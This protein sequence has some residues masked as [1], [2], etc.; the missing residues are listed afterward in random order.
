MKPLKLT[1]QAFGPFVGTQDVD[2]SL[3]GTH[4]L[5][6]I[7]G[8]T[9]AGKST[10]LDAI[11]FALYGKTTGAE[12]EASQMRCDQAP[13][14]VLTQVI[15][16]FELAQKHY[17]IKR[18]PNQP[19]AKARGEGLTEHIGTADLWEIDGAGKEQLIVT[20][21]VRE[22]TEEIER[23]TGL[24]VEQFRQVMVLPQGK[25][26]QLLLADSADREKIFSK[27]FQTDI[28]KRIE[29]ALNEKARDILKDK[30]AHD[31][32][33]MGILEGA[34]LLTEEQLSEQLKHISPELKT[35]KNNKQKLHE[36][37]QSLLTQRES[38]QALQQQF[39]DYHRAMQQLLELEQQTDQ[40]ELNKQALAAA[41]EAI[42]ITPV[43]DEC[44]RIEKQQQ[45]S[46]NKLKNLEIKQS[47][48]QLDFEEAGH[49]LTLAEISASS[50]DDLKQQ[51]LELKRYEAKVEQLEAAIKT[52]QK[53]AISYAKSWN[54]YQDSQGLYDEKISLRK[55]MQDD[56]WRL[57]KKISLLSN[58]P[59]AL[60]QLSQQKLKRI[61]LESSRAEKIH[62]TKKILDV[63]G[64]HKRLT[65]QFITSEI[66]M[67]TLEMGW[68][69]GQAANLAAELHEG[70]P[71][72]VC[73]SRQHPQLASEQEIKSSAENENQQIQQVSL[74]Q[75][76]MAREKIELARDEKQKVRLQLDKLELALAQFEQAIL[77]LT[78]ELA[79]LAHESLQSLEL[80][81]SDLISEVKILEQ[82]EIQVKKLN[83]QLSAISQQIDG[84]VIATS[85]AR[86][87]AEADKILL[88]IEQANVKAIEIEL[89]KELTDKTV[90]FNKINRI[91][92][93]I[94]QLS[95]AL[96]RSQAAAEHCKT[97]LTQHES[98]QQMLWDNIKELGSQLLEANNICLQTLQ[99]S[100]FEDQG[101]YQKSKL[102][103]S[104]LNNLQ[105]SIQAFSQNL[106]HIKGQLVQQELS[107]KGKTEPDISRLEM[108]CDEM[109]IEFNA[110]EKDWKTLDARVDQLK[111]VQKKLKKAHD[112]NL[113]LE[114]NYEIYGTLSN[115]ATGRTGNN[116]SFQ[117]FVLSVLLDDVLIEA[118]RRLNVMTK[119][120]YQLLRKQDRSKGNKASGLEL[121][122]E[123]AY[124]G[125]SRS[126][127][128][129]SG[130]ESFLA[131]L[132]LALGLSDVVQQ[133]A[134]GI[135]LD[136][137][138][139]DEG[140]GSL[141]Q[142]SLDLAIRT[143]IDLQ[144]SGRTIGIISHVTELK[145]LMPL[146]L[147]VISS[148]TG[149]KIHT[150]VDQACYI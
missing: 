126:V 105:L 36:S 37:L 4:P 138:F 12:R 57:D 53:L 85:Q 130:G 13:A 25:F 27:L 43:F 5:F 84:L 145:Q 16:E 6:L 26:R 110:S 76:E 59:M 78:E 74:E 115:V 106:A 60:E 17:R 125:K 19:R 94:I 32:K 56:L 146:R 134:G 80:R 144:A 28:Y 46:E 41:Q 48:L 29:N 118:S 99:A 54:N 81:L 52:Q 96:A 8:A 62:L 83:A 64:Q 100:T 133:Y 1:I 38:A 33:I 117:R 92:Q 98:Q 18:S 75:V 34:D 55:N 63:T 73:G 42:K 136:T 21:K 9:G 135:K 7:N 23:I 3:L 2:F 124:T 109:K 49:A 108:L 147:D 30:K 141:D 90:L 123:D 91:E 102:S 67:K 89:P 103:E 121:D 128:T 39:M 15:F 66:H 65:E 93:K 82:G 107:L 148:K 51:V 35:A 11:C 61:K 101:A 20:K 140:F 72:P 150:V 68:H 97:S 139:I 31:N 119:G 69:L 22:A 142:E 129:L 132:A 50:R 71:C 113:Q 79:Q 95:E 40:N 127:A 70:E 10:I 24:N 111:S 120:R 77:E 87:T 88:E 104:R 131:A 86:D 44:L 122:V 137:L 143:L 114:K 149:S 116:I 58:K 112:V 47:Q 14:D 45:L